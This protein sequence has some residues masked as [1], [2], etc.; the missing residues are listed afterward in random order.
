MRFKKLILIAIFVILIVLACILTYLNYF[1]KDEPIDIGQVIKTEE[2]IF[3]EV[4]SYE[5]SNIIANII[6]SKINLKAPVC[7]GTDLETLNSYVGHFTDT[8]Y[9]DGNICL[10]GHNSGFNTNYFKDLNKLE[11]NDE[12]IYETKYGNKKYIISEISEI[13]ETDLSVLEP[14]N[15]NR[16]TLITCINSKPDKRLCIKAIQI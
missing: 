11:L 7:D 2:E 1:N 8:A 10:A 6:I 16:L 13:A 3:N 4:I 15:D 9:F 14:T 12:I 5:D